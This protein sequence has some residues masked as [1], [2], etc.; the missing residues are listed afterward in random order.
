[1][2]GSAARKRGGSPGSDSR[3]S[4]QGRACSSGAAGSMRSR[5]RRARLCPRARAQASRSRGS[6][7]RAANSRSPSSSGK[8]PG[9][10]GSSPS[11]SRPAGNS[12]SPLKVISTGW[13]SASRGRILISRSAWSRDRR[14]ACFT[15]QPYRRVAQQ[16]VVPRVLDGR[17]EAGQGLGRGALAERAEP[18]LLHQLR[19]EGGVALA[20]GLQGRAHGPAVEHQAEGVLEDLGLRPLPQEGV[21]QVRSTWP[22]TARAPPCGWPSRRWG[23][24]AGSRRAPGCATRRSRPR[25]GCRRCGRRS[26]TR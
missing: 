8:A 9:T 14:A 15:R 11:A 20:E 1:M 7:N 26:G 4:S 18:L 21:P 16:E 24:R 3:S 23:S 17:R 6:A 19:G 2:S 10:Q 5:T 12:C 13:P 22:T 25:P